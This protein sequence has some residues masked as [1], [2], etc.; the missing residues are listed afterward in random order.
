MVTKF[1][2]Y[3]T[4][5]ISNGILIEFHSYCCSKIIFI[6]S[7]ILVAIKLRTSKNYLHY[8]C[9]LSLI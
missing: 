9:I 6:L 3:D 4:S 7:T 2:L 1:D 8:L 5:M